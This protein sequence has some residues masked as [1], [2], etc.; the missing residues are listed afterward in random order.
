MCIRELTGGMYFGDKQQDDNHAF[1]VCS[2]T[3]GEIERIL[4]VAFGYAQRRR[5][6]LTIVDKAN[7]LATSRLWRKVG[8]EIAPNIL[9]WRWNS[10]MSTMPLCA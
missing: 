9:M 3:R 10:C 8:Q 2:Y 4:R 5:R 6:H 1:D 7:V